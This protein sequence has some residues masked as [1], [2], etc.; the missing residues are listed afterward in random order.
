MGCTNHTVHNHTTH[1]LFRTHNNSPF[2]ATTISR[3]LIYR[4]S[5]LQFHHSHSMSGMEDTSNIADPKYVA[6]LE[7]IR[8]CFEGIEREFIA[9]AVEN[10]RCLSPPSYQSKPISLHLFHNHLLNCAVREQL[11]VEPSK[12]EHSSVKMSGPV[13]HP[14]DV[15]SI[16]GLGAKMKGYRDKVEFH[17]ITPMFYMSQFLTF[18]FIVGSILWADGHCLERCPH[19]NASGTST[20]SMEKKGSVY[21]SRRQCVGSGKHNLE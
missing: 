15:H 16:D 13:V 19:G 5:S 8:G 2:I 6:A 3:K 9:L 12:M 10:A 21:W 17:S 4:S 7:R 20:C 1:I 11:G 18:F 14:K